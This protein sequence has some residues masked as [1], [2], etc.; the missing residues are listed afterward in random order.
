VVVITTVNEDERDPSYFKLYKKV[1]LWWNVKK[2]INYC[3]HSIFSAF[4]KCIIAT[5][6]RKHN[7]ATIILF[8]N[9]LK[10]SKINSWKN[11]NSL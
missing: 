10:S 5:I 3:S 2:R 4:Q 8:I 7:Q 9:A 6:N 1:C 11:S